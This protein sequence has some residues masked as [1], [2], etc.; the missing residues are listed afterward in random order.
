MKEITFPVL[1]D[2]VN[3]MEGATFRE[4]MTDTLAILR[5]HDVPMSRGVKEIGIALGV[6]YESV[7]ED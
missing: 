2:L 7:L 1:M 6:F 4:A 5:L 3:E